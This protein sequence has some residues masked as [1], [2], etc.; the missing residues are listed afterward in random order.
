MDFVC[1]HCQHRYQGSDNLVGKEVRC[2]NV[3]CGQ[4]FRVVVAREPP[5]T[6]PQAMASADPQNGVAATAS[7][8][9]VPGPRISAGMPPM[10]PPAAPAE[11]E[12]DP[13][14]FLSGSTA[15]AANPKTT[16]PPRSRRGTGPTSS[17]SAGSTGSLPAS[18][19]PMP[20]AGMP[21][22]PPAADGS[23]PAGPRDVSAMLADYERTA[24]PLRRRLKLTS[25]L[26]MTRVGL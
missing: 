25:R 21:P 17:V 20:P 11:P 15:S 24:K 22:M 6:S 26:K 3:A 23:A 12:G 18:M 4:V 2:K 16:I 10:P 5:I 19:P 7:L 8:A 1:P 9:A 13:L 14:A